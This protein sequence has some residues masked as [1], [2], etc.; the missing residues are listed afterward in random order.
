[1][2]RAV[3]FLRGSV[4]VEASGPFP[5]R[6]LNLCAQ[7][8]VVFW[9]VTWMD[10][11][12]VRIQVPRSARR[13][14]DALAQRAGCTLTEV[15][16][17]GIPAFLARFRRRYSLW[18]G[19]SLSVLAVLFLSHFVLVVDVQGN[20]R[21]P[22]A[23][24][25]ATLRRLGVHP[26]TFS[27]TIDIDN[28]E[29]EVLLELEDLS[30]IAINRSGVRAEV[31]VRERVE[32]PEVVD[33]DE[34]G[35]VIAERDGVITRLEVLSGESDWKVGDPVAKGDVLIRGDVLLEGPL[36]SESD[37]GW[38][39]VR[40]QGQIEAITRR[41]LEAAIPLTAS[42]KQ[43]TGDPERHLFVEWMGRRFDLFS[44]GTAQGSGRKKSAQLWSP[45]LPDG[46]ALPVVVGVE[47]IQ[48]YET[49]SAPVDLAAAE[50]L[51][52]EQL[53]LS[54]RE[55][56]GKGEITHTQFTSVVRDGLLTVTL[57]AD[58]VEEIGRFVP[59]G[60]GGA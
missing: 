42:V 17:S 8:G 28:V 38:Q 22:T 34:L 55:Q 47:R 20:D 35:D 58:C 46:L 19:L 50:D 49:A 18:V 41:T 10:S 2:R 29:E 6:F 51:L 13:S 26:G 27:P 40:A 1:M 43:D 14:L 15:E 57:I 53:E 16:R 11:G 21:V 48:G 23:E 56:V 36:Y 44:W 54:L 32:P 37:V 33:E 39:Q 52:R 9:G 45:Q 30:W 7:R 25:L 59:D 5:E 24:I 31:L 3:N 60:A 12:A 4:E